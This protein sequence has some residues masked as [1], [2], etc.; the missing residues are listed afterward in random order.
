MPPVNTSLTTQS[1]RQ[2]R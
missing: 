1:K 2:S